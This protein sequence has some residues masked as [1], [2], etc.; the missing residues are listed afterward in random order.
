[1]NNIF[2]DSPLLVTGCFRSGTTLTG[3]IFNN[4]PNILC[5]IDTICFLRFSYQRYEPLIN[6]QNLIKLIE[7]VYERINKRWNVTFEIK[8]VIN[9]CLKSERQYSYIWDKL[10]ESTFMKN[11]AKSIWGEKIVLEWRHI[12][13]F[14]KMYPKGRVIHTIRDPRD[15]VASWR[16]MTIAPGNDYM[17]SLLNAIDSMDHAKKYQDIYKN[18]RYFVLKFET[19]LSKPE[20]TLKKACNKLSLHYSSKMLDTTLFRSKDGRKWTSDSMFQDKFEGIS[21]IPV[22]RWRKHL[23][24]VETYIIEKLAK[25]R[26]KYWGYKIT[27][28][29]KKENLLNEAINFIMQS[30]LFTDGVLKFLFTN[31]GLSRF[32]LNPLDPKTWKDEHV[33][34]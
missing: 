4:H 13:D 16:K 1:M 17:D 32:P 7:E 2:C 31:A 14:F 24:D 33:I 20:S 34:T 11:S 28:I 6:D 3:R 29:T 9:D 19:L 23:S 27:D 10:M 30:K 12:A 21:T 22:G 8:D 18:K 5:T 25:H 15:I 26:M